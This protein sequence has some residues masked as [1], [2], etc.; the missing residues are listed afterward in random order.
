MSEKWVYTGNLLSGTGRAQLS[1]E[2]IIKIDPS[3]FLSN[4][5]KN[6]FLIVV[7][8]AKEAMWKTEKK[9]IMTG[10]VISGLAL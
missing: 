3:D 2:S 10:N 8:I 5:V 1:V 7:A 4:E 9:G 6:C